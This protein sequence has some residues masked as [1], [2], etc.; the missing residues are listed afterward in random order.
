MTCCCHFSIDLVV[1]TNYE[2]REDS[3]QSYPKQFWNSTLMTVLSLDI[4]SRRERVS[5]DSHLHLES[6]QDWK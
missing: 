3:T 5:H 2:G 6:E 4:V 1:L